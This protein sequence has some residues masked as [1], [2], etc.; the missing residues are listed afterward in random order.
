MDRQEEALMEEE[1]GDGRAEGFSA[2]GDGGQAA[3]SLTPD[4]HRTHVRIFESSQLEGSYVGDLVHVYTFKTVLNIHVWTSHLF[5]SFSGNCEIIRSWCAAQK[6]DTVW[7]NR[8]CHQEATG[9]TQLGWIRRA[10]TVSHRLPKLFRLDESQ[11]GWLGG[12][13]ETR[14]GSSRPDVCVADGSPSSVSLRN[15]SAG[16]RVS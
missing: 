2:T 1:V 3:M 7:G 5:S 13:M 14:L 4:A 9:I 6:R 15:L 12:F 8:W 10:H 11:D 16:G